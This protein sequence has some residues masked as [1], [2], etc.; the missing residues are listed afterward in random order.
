MFGELKSLTIKLINIFQSFERIL[1]QNIHHGLSPSISDALKSTPRWQFLKS[2][3]PYVMHC[4]AAIL[5]NFAE[6]F[7]NYESKMLYTMHW[8]MLDAASECEIPLADSVHHLSSLQLFVYLFAP[9]LEN[10]DSRHF[11]SLKLHHGLKIWQ[12]L[13]DYSQPKVPSMCAAVKPKTKSNDAGEM[14][15]ICWC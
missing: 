3:F 15:I 5:K 14:N 13:W 10:I 8:L 1:V 11:D 9:L 4:C 2:A 7:S 6:N 12:P